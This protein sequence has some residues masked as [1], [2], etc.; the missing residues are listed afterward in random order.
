MKFFFN[1]GIILLLVSSMNS[2]SSRNNNDKVQVKDSAAIAAKDSTPLAPVA[3]TGLYDQKMKQLANGDTSGR[4]PPKAIYPGE[5]AI[6][7]FKRIVAFYG[8]FYSKG[9]G[10]L[11]QYPLPQVVEK[12]R[13]E[14]SAWELADTTTP[15]IPAIHYIAVTAQPCKIV[16]GKCILRMP[17]AQIDKAVD[18]AAQVKGIVFLDIQLGQSTV[19]QEIPLLKK[20]LL[21]PQVHL[22][23]DPE[24]ALQAGHSPGTAIGTLDAADINYAVAYLASLVKE[25]NLPPKIL[26]VH[27]F[28]N[29]M[30]TNY[31]K[32]TATKEVQVVINMDGFGMPDKKKSTYYY[33]I[34]KE[35]VQFTGFKLFYQNDKQLM[36]PAEIMKLKPQPVYI[37]YQ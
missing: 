4:W 7:P 30:L 17:D 3:D 29:P 10:V 19:Q 21:M 24:F 25:Y 14:V 35:P 16:T 36:T 20:Y 5:G 33:S 34:Y 26:V 31:K 11:G 12:L 2:C 27:R 23:I 9:M 18:L 15:V 32:I 1:A 13:T 28:T 37:Q 8:N 6:L 22:G